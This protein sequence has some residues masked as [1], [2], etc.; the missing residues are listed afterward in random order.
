MIWV[1]P[2]SLQPEEEEFQGLPELGVDTEIHPMT[3]QTLL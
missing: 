2:T 1:Y 3:C